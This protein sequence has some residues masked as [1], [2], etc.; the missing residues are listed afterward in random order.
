[1]GG[2]SIFSALFSKMVGK[3]PVVAERASPQGE[4]AGVAT[5]VQSR[6]TA[7]QAA[8]AEEDWKGAARA[9]VELSNIWLLT[10]DWQPLVAL[11]AQAD[12]WLR[13]HEDPLTRIYLHSRLAV[14]RHRQGDLAESHRLFQEAERWQSERQTA[15][16]W[17]IGLPGSSYCDLLLEQAR[18]QGDWERV[19]HRSQ[20]S[21]KVVKNQ[22]ALAMDCLMQGRALAGL[23]Q[24]EA[25]RVAL[26]QGV[27]LMR[28]ANRRLYLPE[29]LLQQGH[30]LRRVGEVEMARAVWEEAWQMA[31]EESLR[32]CLVD[33]QLLAGHLALDEGEAGA[34]EAALQAAEAEISALQYGQRQGEAALLR[35]RV[36]QRQ[37]REQ[38]AAKQSQVAREEMNARQQWGVLALWEGEMGAQG[39]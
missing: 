22:F 10:G 2:K 19:L 36:W 4:R 16:A 35:A 29:L 18:G 37:G 6:Q 17:L 1:M 12:D 8:Q 11:V 3:A 33:C 28:R 26:Q 27:V 15:Y 21:Q 7:L 14:V 24:S 20:Y 30:F 9:A 23:Q 34:A 32:P 31:Q 25:A 5:L 39:A 38:A 13:R